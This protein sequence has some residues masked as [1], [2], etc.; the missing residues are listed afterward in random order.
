[1]I[2][3]IG[4]GMSLATVTAARVLQGQMRGESGKDNLLHF[5]RFRHTALAKT[6]NTNRQTPDSAG[7]MTAMA[8]GEGELLPDHDRLGA[9]RV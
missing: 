6:Y 7:T 1:M 4:D 3:F 9:C 2:L 5:E 8:T